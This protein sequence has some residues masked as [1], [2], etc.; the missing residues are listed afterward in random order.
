[1][2]L[3]EFSQPKIIDF[4]HNSPDKHF[5]HNLIAQSDSAMNVFKVYYPNQVEE[6]LF[7]GNELEDKHKLHLHLV[8]NAS[9]HL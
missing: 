9:D 1:M 2:K 3:K 7:L 4:L 6:K 5:L 8:F